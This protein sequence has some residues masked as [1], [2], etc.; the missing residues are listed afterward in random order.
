[1][2]KILVVTH[3]AISEAGLV[4]QILQAEGCLLDIRCPATGAALPEHLDNHDGVVIFGGPMS[5]NDDNTLPFIRDELDWIPLVLDARKPYLG[6]CL[7]AQMLARVLGARVAPHPKGWRE[8]GYVSIRPTLNGHNPLAGLTHVYHW[9]KE[10]FELPDGAVLLAT[11]DRFINQAFCYGSSVYGLQFHPEI[12]QSMIDRWTTDGAD[13]LD[14]PGAQPRQI[15]FQGHEQHSTSVASWLH[16]FL[17][18]WLAASSD[19]W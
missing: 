5:A 17:Q 15:Q 11:G 8:I 7:G 10:G 13:Q 14:F 1:M 12:T 16:R 6:I 2:K 19:S 3:Q 9:H 18:Q 4:G